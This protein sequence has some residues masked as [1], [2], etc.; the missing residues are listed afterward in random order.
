MRTTRV[1]SIRLSVSFLTT[2]RGRG[3]SV[4]RER[5][6]LPTPPR[7]REKDGRVRGG[8]LQSHLTRRSWVRRR[9]CST[10]FGCRAT[11]AIRRE[12]QRGFFFPPSPRR[13]PRLKAPVG[14]TAAFER[15]F[16][17]VTKQT[18]VGCRRS[19]YSKS[20]LA[21]DSSHVLDGDY[22]GVERALPSNVPRREE[23]GELP[24]HAPHDGVVDLVLLQNLGSLVPTHL[25]RRGVQS[26]A[27][28]VLHERLQR[29]LRVRRRGGTRSRRR[30]G[31]K[32][33]KK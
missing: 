19:G 11:P 26:R 18:R 10:R 13:L 15:G 17:R 27:H 5:R 2:R 31:Q 29:G 24:G 7:H 21:H 23:P 33:R 30:T 20:S 14:R 4:D 16:A 12:G 1:E 8:S 28:H 25:G 9:T 22:L 6:R 32:S 3:E